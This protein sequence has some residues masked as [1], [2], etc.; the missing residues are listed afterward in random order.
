VAVFIPASG[1][2]KLYALEFYK[3]AAPVQLQLPGNTAV[4][5]FGKTGLAGAS[6]WKPTRFQHKLLE[7]VVNMELDKVTIRNVTA[8]PIIDM[9]P[10][11]K[12]KPASLIE[13]TVGGKNVAVLQNEAGSFVEFA[14]GSALYAPLTANASGPLA[15][16]IASVPSLSSLKAE[17]AARPLVL[18]PALDSSCLLALADAGKQSAQYAIAIIKN[19]YSVV[20]LTDGQTRGLADQG[21]LDSY[22]A[23]LGA[24]GPRVRLYIATPNENDDGS[25]SDARIA[26]RADGTAGQPAT[27]WLSTATMQSRASS[28]K[29]GE[30]ICATEPAFIHEIETVPPPVE[31]PGSKVLNS[32]TKLDFGSDAGESAEAMLRDLSG[33][34]LVWSHDFYIDPSPLLVGVKT[35]CPSQVSNP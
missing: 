9:V 2:D 27:W 3:G 32:Q 11:W 19:A 34:R 1:Q 14:E 17:G 18:R 33:S 8:I 16:L 21:W 29:F 22:C 15:S 24:L 13:E 12:G 4:A 7:R 30:E 26:A 31:K 28:A 5:I 35:Q 23:R 10:E 6:Q 20:H 25:A